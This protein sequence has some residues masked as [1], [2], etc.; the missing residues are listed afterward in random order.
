M[1]VGSTYFALRSIVDLRNV[2]PRFYRLLKKASSL[3]EGSDPIHRLSHF[4]VLT[5]G[6]FR[7]GH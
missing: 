3:D 4:F 5:V 7:T 2:R 1:V 6:K